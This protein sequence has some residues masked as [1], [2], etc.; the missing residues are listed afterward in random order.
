MP[1]MLPT[2]QA[3]ELRFVSQAMV[4]YLRSMADSVAWWRRLVTLPEG[5]DED[6]TEQ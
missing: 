1:A 3:A 2:R 4:W 5:W 6:A